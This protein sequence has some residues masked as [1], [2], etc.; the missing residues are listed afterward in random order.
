MGRAN[1]QAVNSPDS[2]LAEAN[3]REP[4]KRAVTNTRI[5]RQQLLSLI[6]DDGDRLR[7]PYSYVGDR[8]MQ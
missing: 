1:T 6:A 7:R 5:S 2:G 4:I 3:A 8:G